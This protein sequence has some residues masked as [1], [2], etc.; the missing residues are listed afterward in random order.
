MSERK[1]GIL[2]LAGAILLM[3][4]ALLFWQE[5]ILDQWHKIFRTG[6]RVVTSPT[7]TGQGPMVQGTPESNAPSREPVRKVVPKSA[8]EAVEKPGELP[9]SPPLPQV[10][11]EAGQTERKEASGL[12]KSL[13]HI[14]LKDEPFQIGG[15]SYTIDQILSQLGKPSELPALLPEIRE[16]DIG[17]L[18]RRPIRPRPP[19]PGKE[20]T[21]YGVRVVQPYENVWK[22][23]FGVLR[24]Y[25]ARRQV[26]LPA[27][28]DQPLADGRS[29]GVARMLKFIE[30][31]VTVYDVSENRVEKDINLIHP[32]SVIIFF[33]I[34]DLF[35]VLDQ[36]QPE[37]WAWLRYVKG[38]IRL[39]RAPDSVELLNRQ[40]F[41]E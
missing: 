40:S 15:K 26:L 38:S 16:T 5:S 27:D 23:H 31:V 30:A 9:P 18:V 13:D 36:I 12:M 35:R 21:Y 14:L 41:A 17:P 3:G 4:G 10:P 29:S 19:G 32:N 24:E 1:S 8:V 25:L 33:K 6:D 20:R 2:V 22:I 37:D 39:D 28:A 11:V 7:D 34:S